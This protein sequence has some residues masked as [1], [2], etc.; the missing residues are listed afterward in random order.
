MHVLFIFPIL[1]IC[2]Y[3]LL[4]FKLD[5]FDQYIDYLENANLILSL[6]LSVYLFICLFVY[7]IFVSFDLETCSRII[8]SC[9]TSLALYGYFR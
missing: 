4:V 1:L 2:Y 9:L 8:N 3:N 7:V 6:S 5:L